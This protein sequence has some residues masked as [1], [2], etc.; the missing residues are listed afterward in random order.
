MSTVGHRPIM[1]TGFMS[2][3]V[4]LLKTATSSFP[5]GMESVVHAV[6]RSVELWLG[7]AGVD[8]GSGALPLP[9]DV[10]ASLWKWPGC[11]TNSV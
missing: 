5:G 1:P 4:W 9:V 11:R 7:M 3:V 10:M 6:P 2:R 8:G